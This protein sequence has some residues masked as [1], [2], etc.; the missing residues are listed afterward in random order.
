MV[1]LPGHVAMEQRYLL[2]AL[3]GVTLI[4]LAFPRRIEAPAHHHLERCAPLS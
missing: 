1:R 2:L 4:F 3:V